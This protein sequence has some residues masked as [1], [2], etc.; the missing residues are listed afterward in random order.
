MTR[1]NVLDPEDLTDSH[2][3]AEYRELPMVHGSLA[4]TLRSKRGV[5]HSRI[6]P[7]YTLNTGHVYQFYPRG[8]WLYNRYQALIAELKHRGYDIHPSERSVDWSI[9]K[10]NGLYGDWIPDE[11]SYRVN[12]DRIL[13]RISQKPEF[14]TLNKIKIN[15]IEYSSLIKEKYY[16]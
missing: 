5:D 16:K 3:M 12:G 2:L 6:S 14:Y 13:L 8:L 1:I 15:M 4:R 7:V 10:D 9:F 11:N